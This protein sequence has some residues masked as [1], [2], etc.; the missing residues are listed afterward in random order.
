MN[1]AFSSLTPAQ[2]D[3]NDPTRHWIW[4]GYL[5]PGQITL[6]TSVWKSGK[7]TLLAHLLGR[8][9]AG[10][11]LAGKPVSAGASIVVSEEAKPH[12]Q[13]RHRR[14]GCGARDAFFLR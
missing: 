11:E 9:R 8:R 1:E 3:D 14:L 5:A 2:F 13:E 10:G 4:E 7:T 12:W 6:F